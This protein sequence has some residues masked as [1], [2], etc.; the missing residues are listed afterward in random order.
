MV[1]LVMGIL[2]AVAAPRLVSKLNVHSV[3]SA[4]T[5]VQT[6]LQ[7]AQQEAIA[8][9][10]SVTFTHNPQGQPSVFRDRDSKRRENRHSNGHI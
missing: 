4:T 6:D 3:G 5:L 7:A 10:S 2:T 9:S 8:T 1:L